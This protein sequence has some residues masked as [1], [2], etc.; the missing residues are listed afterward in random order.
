MLEEWRWGKATTIRF[1][2]I[3][4]EL[5]H[6]RNWRKQLKM[7]RL[8]AAH[9]Q[10]FAGK[11]RGHYKTFWLLKPMLFCPQLQE[12][13]W[14]G[15]SFTSVSCAWL[16]V[17]TRN[18]VERRFYKCSSQASTPCSVGKS[19]EARNSAEWLTHDPG[20]WSVGSCMIHSI[21][22]LQPQLSHSSLIPPY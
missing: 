10:W 21:A 16:S 9:K 17:A 13:E 1:A 14:H 18:S 4:W 12:E 5:R 3:F 6:F 15:F 2:A 20:R 8:S 11:C 7:L 22:L 19:I